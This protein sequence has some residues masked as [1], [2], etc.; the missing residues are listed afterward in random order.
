MKPN[1]LEK[2]CWKGSTAAEETGESADSF[3]AILP[4]V[5]HKI[6]IRVDHRVSASSKP[7]IKEMKNI[8][9]FRSTDHSAGFI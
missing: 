5:H 2:E 1:D 7:L 8:P 6:R 3:L 9:S 4:E